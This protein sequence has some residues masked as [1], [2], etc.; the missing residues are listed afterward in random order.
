MG[1]DD[2]LKHIFSLLEIK[3]LGCKA[4]H[5][6]SDGLQYFGGL[7]RQRNSKENPSTQL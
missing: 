7:C 3:G 2:S 6:G 5:S 1:I 4:V